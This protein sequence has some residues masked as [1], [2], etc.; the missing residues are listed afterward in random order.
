VS[1]PNFTTGTPPNMGNTGAK[2][3]S[4]VLANHS[5]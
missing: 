1:I 3:H 2:G 5:T 4:T